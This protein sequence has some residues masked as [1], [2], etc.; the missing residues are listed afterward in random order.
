MISQNLAQVTSFLNER[1]AHQKSHADVLNFS[2]D[3]Y[4]TENRK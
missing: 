2:F 3:E 1:M 4:N